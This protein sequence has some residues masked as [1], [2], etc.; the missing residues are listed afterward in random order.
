[1]NL[2]KT[3][4]KKL[5]LLSVLILAGLNFSRAQ[6]IASPAE[7]AGYIKVITARA[8]KIVAVLGITDSAKFKRVQGIIINQYENLSAIH[9]ARNAKVKEIKQQ[10]DKMAANKQIAVI[11]SNVDNQLNN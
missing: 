9:D 3:R 5:I 4:M 7:K 6:N 11:D 2:E 10:S 8:E 1:M